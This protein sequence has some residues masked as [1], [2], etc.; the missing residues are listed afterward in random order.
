MGSLRC[1]GV[2]GVGR[3]VE[4]SGGVEWSGGRERRGGEWSGVR[5]KQDRGEDLRAGSKEDK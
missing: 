5:S 3:G 4:G 2:E 1:G